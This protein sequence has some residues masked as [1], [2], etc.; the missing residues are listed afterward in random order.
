MKVYVINPVKGRFS[1]PAWLKDEHSVATPVEAFAHK[2]SAIHP[3]V[4]FQVEP[5]I[6]AD[7]FL[8]QVLGNVNNVFFNRFR[9]MEAVQANAFVVIGFCKNRQEV[10]A[11]FLI[12]VPFAA[13][14]MVYKGAIS[15]DTH[16]AAMGVRLVVLVHFPEG[17]AGKIV[18]RPCN[19]VAA[20]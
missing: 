3:V 5:E 14:G 4:C 1:Y 9:Y 7:A 11:N 2:F 12:R 17:L 8:V 16:D 20:C 15:F 10:P 6:E 19:E 13:Q 18:P